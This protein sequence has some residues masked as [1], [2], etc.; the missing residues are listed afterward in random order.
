M[1]LKRYIHAERAGLW[2][3][4]LAEVGAMLLYLVAA[5]HCKYVSFL[6]RYLEVMIG[7]SIY[8]FASNKK[9]VYIFLTLI[10]RIINYGN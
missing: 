2:E 1:L 4:H 9:L 3:K 8:I 5:G 10:A 6:P 7:L